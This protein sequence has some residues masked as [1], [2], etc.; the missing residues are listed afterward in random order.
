VLEPEPLRT[1]LGEWLQNP[2][3]HV[4]SGQAWA[5]PE[6]HTEPRNARP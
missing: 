6:H 5:T 1:L 2:G 3:G 4:V